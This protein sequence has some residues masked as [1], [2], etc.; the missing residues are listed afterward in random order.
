M[1]GSQE[2]LPQSVAGISGAPPSC[3][4]PICESLCPAVQMDYQG[5]Q[6]ETYI[7]KILSPK[8][9]VSRINML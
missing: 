8:V 3:L 5:S 7:P 6:I 2:M 1:T 9:M 4:L